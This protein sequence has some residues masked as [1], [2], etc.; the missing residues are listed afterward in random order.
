[1]EID[2][3]T[4]ITNGLKKQVDLVMLMD[5]EPLRVNLYFYNWQQFIDN[6]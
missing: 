4:I 2:G 1:M 5:R 3:K 6:F